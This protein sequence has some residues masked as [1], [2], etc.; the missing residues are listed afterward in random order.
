MGHEGKPREAPADRKADGGG[1]DAPARLGF[2]WRVAVV[3]W[4]LAF[5]GLVLSELWDFFWRGVRR[6]F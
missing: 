6:L 3:L 2:G 4:A 1:A 5:G